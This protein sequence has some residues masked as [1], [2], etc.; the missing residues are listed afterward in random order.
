M[1]KKGENNVKRAGK[2]AIPP[3][4]NNDST[5]CYRKSNWRWPILTAADFRPDP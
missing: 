5:T 3:D 1:R 4:Q 2:A